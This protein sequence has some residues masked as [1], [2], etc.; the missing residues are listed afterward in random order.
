MSNELSTPSCSDGGDTTNLTVVP[1]KEINY[2]GLIFP[3]YI[4]PA[5]RD[6]NFT[7]AFWVLKIVSSFICFGS[8]QGR[9]SF[10][11]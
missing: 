11:A 9:G 6:C 4:G 5:G 2:Y 8:C 3:M 7:E 1:T 10:P